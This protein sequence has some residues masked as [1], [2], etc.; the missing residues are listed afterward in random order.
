MTQ[1]S[2]KVLKRDI[3]ERMQEVFLESIA[4]V[5]TK[6][7]VEKLVDDLLSPTEKIM[8]A[9]R[10]A[11]AL[12]LLKRYDQR[13][14]SNLLKV[15]LTTVNKVSRALQRGTGGYG[16]VINAIVR[17]EKFHAFLE[18]LDDTLAEVV[19]AGRSLPHWRRA[20]WE[21]K[22]RNRKPF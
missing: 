8:L 21:A 17:Q 5:K 19:T 10:I 2:R 15:G 6:G 12:L 20:R 18:K 7:S 11:I 13:A 1:V 3:E 22:I 16:M 9:K 4:M 14:V